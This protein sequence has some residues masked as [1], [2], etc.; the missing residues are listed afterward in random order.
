[1]VFQVLQKL[2]GDRIY[3][4]FSGAVTSPPGRIN[5]TGQLVLDQTKMLKVCLFA[6]GE[7]VNA[8]KGSINSVGQLVLGP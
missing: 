3:M 2:S 7:C 4:R 8:V 1:M 5:F 6:L